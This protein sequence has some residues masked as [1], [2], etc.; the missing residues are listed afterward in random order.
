LPILVRAVATKRFNDLI[1]ADLRAERE[2]LQL[3]GGLE[4]LTC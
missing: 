4:P 1:T 3:W 2:Q